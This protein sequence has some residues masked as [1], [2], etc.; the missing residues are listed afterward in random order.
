VD[1]RSGRALHPLHRRERPRAA[2]TKIRIDT[3]TEAFAMQ[4][5]KLVDDAAMPFV[6]GPALDQKQ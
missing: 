5:R 2:L 4:V 3:P 1:R 6:A